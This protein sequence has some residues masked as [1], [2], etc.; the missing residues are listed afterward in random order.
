MIVSDSEKIPIAKSNINHCIELFADIT[1]IAPLLAYAQHVV[2]IQSDG[3]LH[4][5][6]PYFFVLIGKEHPAAGSQE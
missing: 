3:G 4:I 6:C 5:H 1:T 2:V